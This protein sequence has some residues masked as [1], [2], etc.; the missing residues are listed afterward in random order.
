MVTSLIVVLSL[1]WI[2]GALLTLKM[3][4]VMCKHP[5]YYHLVDIALALMFWVPIAIL[6]LFTEHECFFINKEFRY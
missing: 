4:A 3:E 5:T 2:L 6:Y 1:C